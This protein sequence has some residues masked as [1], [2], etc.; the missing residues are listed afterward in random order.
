[1]RLSARSYPHPVVGNRDDVPGSAFQSAIEV[2]TDKENIYLELTT[3][4]SADDLVDM[5][6]SADAVYAVHVEC[7]NTLY[8]AVFE[9]GESAKRIAIPSDNL[10]DVV[11][12]NTFVIAKR[13][14]ATYRVAGAHPDYGDSFFEVGKG[15]IL[16]VA[17]GYVFSVESFFDALG[18]IGSIMQIVES[19]EDGDRAM[20]IDWNRDKITVVLAKPDFTDYKLL[21]GQDAVAAPLTCAIVLPVLTEALRMIAAGEIDDDTLRW[22]RVLRARADALGRELTSSTDCLTLAQ[23]LLEL[24]LRRALAAARQLAEAA[25]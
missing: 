21:R 12:V 7:S 19:P 11:E 17:D 13:A 14:Q 22:A 15:D 25:S 8:R 3:A 24:P 18:R 16:A 10:N 5:I 23:E 9:F 2:T 4:C 20:V 6:R 1:M